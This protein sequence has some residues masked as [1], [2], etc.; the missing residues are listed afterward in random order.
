MSTETSIRVNFYAIHKR[1]AKL[2]HACKMCGSAIRAGDIYYRESG[3]ENGEF[4][5]RA[6]CERCYAARAETEKGDNP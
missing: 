5:N 2:D 1:A 6:I 4:F 3:K